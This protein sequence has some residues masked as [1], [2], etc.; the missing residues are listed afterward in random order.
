MCTECQAESDDDYS[1]NSIAEKRRKAVTSIVQRHP[2]LGV[3]PEEVTFRFVPK[4]KWQCVRINLNTDA[5]KYE[6]HVREAMGPAM[7]GGPPLSA[8]AMVAFVETDRS[9]E[10]L[11]NILG[12]R[13]STQHE[14]LFVS[15][16]PPVNPVRVQ[17]HGDAHEYDSHLTEHH[18][19]ND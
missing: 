9:Y 19:E 18:A 3:Q 14:A 16:Q 11:C 1:G 17:S 6:I 4:Y 13:P 7:R 2:E 8:L 15:D 12:T 5:P 10:E